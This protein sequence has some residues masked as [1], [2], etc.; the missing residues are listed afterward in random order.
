MTFAIIVLFSP[1]YR[2]WNFFVKIPIIF[3]PMHTELHF[4]KGHGDKKCCITAAES[5][6]V[7][8][9]NGFTIIPAL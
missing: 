4:F 3:G 5:F 9:M 6:R 1:K 2:I 7:I 8:P